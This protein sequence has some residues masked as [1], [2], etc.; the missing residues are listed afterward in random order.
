MSTN[1]LL[2]TITVLTAVMIVAMPACAA[3]R[4]GSS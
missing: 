2:I 4:T 3:G 1:V